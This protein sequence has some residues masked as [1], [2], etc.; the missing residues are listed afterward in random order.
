MEKAGEALPPP[1]PALPALK[2]TVSE[3]R[4]M[5][6]AIES[7][8]LIYYVTSSG[9]IRPS[10]SSRAAEGFRGIRPPHSLFVEGIK[11]LRCLACRGM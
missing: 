7:E 6:E 11:R 10:T 4:R 8:V 3:L 1:S 9:F 2:A 5:L